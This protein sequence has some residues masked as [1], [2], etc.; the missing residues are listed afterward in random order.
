MEMDND[1][2]SI[3]TDLIYFELRSDDWGLRLRDPGKITQI[4]INNRQMTYFRS[5]INGRKIVHFMTRNNFQIHYQ[6]ML[7]VR[8]PD[9]QMIHP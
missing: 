3:H 4:H 6:Q 9:H 2:M 5:T 1:K 7:F 8:T